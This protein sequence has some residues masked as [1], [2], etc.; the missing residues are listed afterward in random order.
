MNDCKRLNNKSIAVLIIMLAMFVGLL[1]PAALDDSFNSLKEFSTL[2]GGIH[3]AG[4]FSNHDAINNIAVN[5][6]SVIDRRTVRT[7]SN[8]D[9][10]FEDAVLSAALGAH[11]YSL[12]QRFYKYAAVAGFLFL[13][14]IY[15]YYIH[16][17]DGQ[18]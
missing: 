10:S 18:K 6:P 9:T 14:L 11:S 5:N 7:E 3:A 15:I 1:S 13:S 17:S 12:L 16:L 4:G 8:R 2:T